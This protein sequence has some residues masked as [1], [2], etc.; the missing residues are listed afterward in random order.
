M[1]EENLQSNDNAFIRRTIEAAIHIGLLFLLVVWCY[2]IIKPFIIPVVWGV[3]ITV[4]IY[5]LY[6]KLQSAMGGRQKLAAT[7]YTLLALAL[8][9][10][11]TIMVAGSIVESSKTI[12]KN[13]QQGKLVVP[14]PKQS[15]SEWPL[16]GKDLYK[17]WSEA[18]NN[19]EDTLKQ[20]ESQLKWAGK[21]I[22]SA[23]AG[24]GAAVLT[25]ILSIIISGVLLANAHASY[26]I[27]LKIV[28]R[29]SGEQQGMQLINL[30]GATIRSVAQGVLGV[31]LIQ[32]TLAAIGMITI[33]VPGWGLWTVLVLVLAVAQL[34]PIL[35]LGP[36]AAYV[37]SYAD[38]T[39]AVIFLIWSLVVSMSD[40]LLKPLFLGRGMETPM[41]VILLGA[42]GGMISSGIIGL[43]IG[44][45]VLALS[46][47]LFMAWLDQDSQQTEKPT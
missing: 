29:I 30:T 26:N 22:I 27:A 44:A 47:E 35:I 39:P 9:I 23:A 20:Y 45:I 14:P 28:R 25:F 1:K 2:D 40:G 16:V 3:I 33:G 37:F 43:F 21:A 11:P 5:P 24:A 4:A 7:L 31:A 36:V 17:V 15:V 13:L 6:I 32:S 12:A 46:Y 18:A 38:T 42:I 8:L 19:L 34:P 10:S 41:L